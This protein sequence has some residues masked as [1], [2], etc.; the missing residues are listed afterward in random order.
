MTADKRKSQYLNALG[1]IVALTSA[2]DVAGD[3]NKWG[4]DTQEV[5][6]AYLDRLAADMPYL[7][8]IEAIA[9][10]LRKEMK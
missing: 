8:G 3:P 9:D 7:T 2:V 1:E 4:L 10:N 6:L 5:A